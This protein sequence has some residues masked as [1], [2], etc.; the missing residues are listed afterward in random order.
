MSRPKDSLILKC[1]E[2]RVK[3]DSG[4]LVAEEENHP[5]PGKRNDQEDLACKNFL[6]ILSTFFRVT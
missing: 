6:Y 2:F 4:G 5:E 1:P 3:G